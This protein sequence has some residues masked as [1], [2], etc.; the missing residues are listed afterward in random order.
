MCEFF[1]NEDFLK[2]ILQL[3]YGGS[4]IVKIMKE[5][6]EMDPEL[7]ID[8]FLCILD[9]KIDPSTSYMGRS[10]GLYKYS[11]ELWNKYIFDNYKCNFDLLI[12]YKNLCF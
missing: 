8:V 1:E 6:K 2:K 3:P 4:K 12:S 7:S 5:M 11:I 9:K 10:G